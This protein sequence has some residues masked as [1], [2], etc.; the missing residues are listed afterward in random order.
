MLRKYAWIAEE[1]QHF[2]KPGT[3]Y[4]FA[5][6]DW[7]KAEDDIA[8]LEDQK[9]KLG[10]KVDLRGMNMLGQTED[11]YNDLM[12]KYEKVLGDK[13]SLQDFIDQLDKK[14]VD[15]INKAHEQVD[16]VSVLCVCVCVS[17][18][19]TD[20]WLANRRTSTR[21]SRRCCRAVGPA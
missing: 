8:K 16:R 5:A 10:R 13:K 19:V 20:G 11:R 3:I 6:K 18:D 21:S 14:K 17:S 9:K 7:R 4:D 15:V 2:N 1:R 12:S